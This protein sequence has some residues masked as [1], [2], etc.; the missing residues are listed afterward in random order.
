M[1]QRQP[2][3]ALSVMADARGWAPLG[4]KRFVE[5]LFKLLSRSANLNVHS[6]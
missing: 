2:G 3:V 4:A 6:V 1:K 5:R